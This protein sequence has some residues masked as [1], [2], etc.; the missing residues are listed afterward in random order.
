MIPVQQKRDSNLNIRLTTSQRAKLEQIAT[1][2]VCSVSTVV[3]HLIT[4]FKN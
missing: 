1:D 2:N 4:N 3:R